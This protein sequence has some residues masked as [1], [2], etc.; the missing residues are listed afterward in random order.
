MNSEKIV[1]NLEKLKSNTI[2][3]KQE[4]ILS[5]VLS[6]RL[7][8]QLLQ[9]KLKLIRPDLEEKSAREIRKTSWKR[10]KSTKTSQMLLVRLTKIKHSNYLLLSRKN[11]NSMSRHGQEN[12]KG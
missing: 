5:Q 1:Q 8:S 9:H 6:K 11:L 10:L 12:L 3:K 2:F 4:S 7:K